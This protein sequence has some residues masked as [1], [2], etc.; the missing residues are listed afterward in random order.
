[1]HLF[2]RA[3]PLK[4]W[5]SGLLGFLLVLPWLQPWSPAPLPNVVPLLVSWACMGLLMAVG[6]R[7]RPLDIAKAW[8]WAA[9]AAAIRVSRSWGVLELMPGL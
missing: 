5:H 1:M 2:D 3:A 6:L 7:I 8:A 4:A 9:L